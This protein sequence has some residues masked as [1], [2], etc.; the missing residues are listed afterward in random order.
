MTDQGSL[1]P[2]GLCTGVL[3]LWAYLLL[4]LFWALSLNCWSWSY[5][6]STVLTCAYLLELIWSCRSVLLPL[7]ET[8]D[9]YAAPLWG[10]RL[11]LLRLSGLKISTVIP[12]WA[13][14]V[15]VIDRAERSV[16]WV[17]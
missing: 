10:N 13:C 12:V 17:L 8:I 7:F 6:S 16:L 2:V 4:S 11:L 5:T 3:N 14:A 1:R 9:L 15:G